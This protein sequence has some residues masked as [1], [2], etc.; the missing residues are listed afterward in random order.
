MANQNMKAPSG[1]VGAAVLLPDGTSVSVNTSG[2]AAIP[3]QFVNALEGGG[4]EQLANGITTDEYRSGASQAAVATTGS[5][6]SSPYGYTTAAQ[7]DAIPVI[8][9]EIRATLIAL[10]VWKGG[11]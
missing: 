8:L 6:T 9:N 2:I 11:A 10:G 7:A 5:T 3:I 4:W 1:F